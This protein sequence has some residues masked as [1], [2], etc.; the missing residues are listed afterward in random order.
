[1]VGISG[2]GT[3]IVPGD[4]ERG[5]FIQVEGV[6]HSEPLN[7]DLSPTHPTSHIP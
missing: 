5:C 7:P 1:M 4:Q 3:M 2:T 6:G